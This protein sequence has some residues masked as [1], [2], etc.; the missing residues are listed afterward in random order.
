M[1]QALNFFAFLSV[2]VLIVPAASAQDAEFVDNVVVVVDASGSMN[3]SL[4]NIRKMHAAKDAMKIVLTNL[5]DSVQVGVLV[6][7]SCCQDW[8]YP[9]GPK[10]V[11]ALV[12]SIDSINGGGGTPLGEYIKKGADRLLRQMKKQRG[13]GSYRLLVVTDGEA[14]DQRLVD[15]FTPDVISRGIVMDVIGVG[16]R[17]DHTLAT[18]VHTYRRANDPASLEKAVSQVFAEVGNSGK[19]DTGEDLFEIT[20]SLSPEVAASLLKA[21]SMPGTHPIGER[22]P[23]PAVASTGSGGSAQTASSPP[24]QRPVSTGCNC[25]GSGSTIIVVLVVLGLF[26]LLR[27]RRRQ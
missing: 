17:N 26:L 20:E 6:F 9:L 16:M 1:R 5:P 19:D 25:R 7:G 4:G 11:A 8:V 14:G 21:L 27:R 12:V 23:E 22:A 24:G 15:R 2:T 3:D 18:K 13:Y 10:D